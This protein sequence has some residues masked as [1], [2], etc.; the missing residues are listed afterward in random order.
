LCKS[1]WYSNLLSLLIG[2]PLCCIAAGI[3]LLAANI[4]E[5][6]ASLEIA[7]TFMIS[8]IGLSFPKTII[9]KKVLNMPLIFMFVGIA[10]TA[11]MA[12]GF[13]YFNSLG[14]WPAILKHKKSQ[15]G[16]ISDC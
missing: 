11:A 16:F 9:L 12:R 15:F 14:S 6:V 7:L 5:K 13:L 4:I 8:V 3:I 2:I 1:A 10:A